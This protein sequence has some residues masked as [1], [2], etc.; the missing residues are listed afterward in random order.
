MGNPIPKKNLVSVIIPAFNEA[1][2]IGSVIDVA[3]SHPLVGEV[4][5]VDDGSWDETARVAQ[6]KGVE[7]CRLE[8]N[9]GKARAMEEGVRAASYRVIQFFDADLIGLTGEIITKIATPVLWGDTDM[10]VGICGRRTEFTNKYLLPYV[11]K[12]G[13]QRA[14]TKELWYS[15]PEKNKH[16]F[17]IEMALNYFC[18]KNGF[19]RSFTIFPAL[20]Q[21]RKESKRGFFWG[22]YHR[23][24]MYR[25]LI[26]VTTRLY[27]FD[28]THIFFKLAKKRMLKKMLAR[29]YSN[30]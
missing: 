15:V 14:L 3:K 1:K 28:A 23:V 9:S 5:V 8:K 13:G 7:V 27:I 24:F 30:K 2:T 18:D 10:S 21:V 19:R 6:L 11:L 16:N 26:L 29:K 22:M 17:E 12:L 25:D 20:G 4:I